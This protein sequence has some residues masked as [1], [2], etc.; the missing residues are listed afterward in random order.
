VAALP[1]PKKGGGRPL[2]RGPGEFQQIQNLVWHIEA[3]AARKD[4]PQ[5]ALRALLPLARH[6]EPELRAA[7]LKGLGSVGVMTPEVQEVFRAA[8]AAT[9]G[10]S[11]SAAAAALAL[12]PPGQR[13]PLVPQLLEL[14][15]DPKLNEDVACPA[16]QLLP[17]H[18]GRYGKTILARLRVQLRRKAYG[19]RDAALEAARGIGPAAAP[20]WPDLLPFMKEFYGAGYW[21]AA[22]AVDPEGKR[23]VPA[24]VAA[25]NYRGS[26]VRIDVL[27]ALAVYKEKARA[28]EAAVAKLLKHRDPAVRNAAEETL[29][30]IRG[31][32]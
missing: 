13:E 32:G 29:K 9:K 2:A 3:L 11:A 23:A 21:E 30:A 28:A 10:E 14:L 18:M 8:L 7:A 24:L 26:E 25:L 17:A 20:L 6:G 1:P 12:L 15:A 27:R 19:P 4:D 5:A 31:E 22:T 16:I